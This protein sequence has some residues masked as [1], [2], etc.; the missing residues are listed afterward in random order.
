MTLER[1]WTIDRVPLGKAEWSDSGLRAPAR[2]GRVGVQQYEDPKTGRRFGVLRLPEEVFHPDSLRSFEMLPVTNGHP[3]EMV[4]PANATKYAIGAA[5]HVERD[6]EDPNYIRAQVSIW[7][8][9]GLADVRAGREEL[10]NGYYAV[11]EPA[12][13]GSTYKDPVTGREDSY[14]F[15]QR[16]IRGN[17]I[18]IVDHGRAG[19]GAR[20]FV[21]SANTREVQI[22]CALID[23][24]RKT[25]TE[26]KKE[27]M[28]KITLDG[29]TYEVSPQVLQALGKI[30]AT[31]AEK[32]KTLTT[33]ADTV[34][35]ERDGLKVQ[36]ADLTKKLEAATDPK[37][38]ES[39]IAERLEISA[40]AKTHG[41][42]DAADLSLSQ[43]QRKVIAK[44]APTVSL[45]GKG[46]DYVAGVFSQL[47]KS[48]PTQ[49]VGKNL[50]AAIVTADALP[51]GKTSAQKFNDAFFANAAN[52][53]NPAK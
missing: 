48:E 30:T 5:A 31:H 25:Q 19:P 49:G 13:A 36:V 39:R 10:S 9:A 34:R 4:T 14:E 45:D 41:I 32:I 15:V 16:E 38:I 12:P 23:N 28:E 11:R 3:P 1:V 40:L 27:T 52:A 53:A 50:G 26:G 22:D 51:S 37:A 44:L 6:P 7:D 17:H 47:V 24:D 33:D 42:T 35:G 46:D 29:V 8:A 2:L 20:M 18:A 43:V 21:D